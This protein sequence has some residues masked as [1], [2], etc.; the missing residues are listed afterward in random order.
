MELEEV[1]EDDIDTHQ[2]YAV[3]SSI[4]ERKN[5]A[6]RRIIDP[7]TVPKPHLGIVG[8]EPDPRAVEAAI[9]NAPLQEPKQAGQDHIAKPAVRTEFAQTGIIRESSDNVT[10]RMMN[11]TFRSVSLVS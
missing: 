7:S 10:F 1:Y 6:E 4:G 9:A 3:K 2:V 11:P 8:T 5:I